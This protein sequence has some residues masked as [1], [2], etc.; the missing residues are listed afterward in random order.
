M[1]EHIK[2]ETET[3]DDEPVLYV[4]TNLKLAEAGNELYRS[5]ES[6]EEGTPLAQALSV[7]HGITDLRI[8]GSDLVV[9][10]DSASTW[11]AIIG[12][13]TSV[14]KEFFL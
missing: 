11:H 6:M 7:V 13:I 12:D 10:R 9:T 8:E 4:F 5:K 3:S 2:I 14:L 1:S